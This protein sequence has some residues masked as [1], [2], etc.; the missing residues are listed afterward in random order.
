M[1]AALDTG[2]T[3]T[4]FCAGDG[5]Q[6]PTVGVWDFEEYGVDY[7]RLGAALAERLAWLNQTYVPSRVA[8]EAP[9]L[10]TKRD[11][12]QWLRRRYG[13]DFLAETYF[14]QKGIDVREADLRRVKAAVTGD[15][16]AKKPRIVAAAKACGIQLP[17]GEAA[18][19]AADAWAVWFYELQFFDP[20]AFSVWDQRVRALRGG[21]I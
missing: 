12:L 8:F 3:R 16:D 19:D 9:I 1:L 18:K 4:G 11:T 5:S 14:T 17:R 6:I 2:P 15:H 13:M 20:Q 7:G 10:V 21:L